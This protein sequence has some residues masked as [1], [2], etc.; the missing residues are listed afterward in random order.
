MNQ[1][2]KLMP[3]V[4]GLLTQETYNRGDIATI[5]T[6][7][8][9]EVEVEVFNLV[10][11]DA[12][13][14]RIYSVIRA[15]G[16]NSQTRAE[17]KAERRRQWAEGAEQKSN[18]FYEKSN[19]HRDFLSLG[20][21]IK[22]GHH[23][24]GRHRRI[25]EQANNNMGK[26]VELTKKADRHEQV[27]EYWERRAKDINL[28]MPESLEYFEFKLEE[29]TK[30]QQLLKDRPELREHSYSLTYASKAVKDITKKIAIAR[31]LWAE[32]EAK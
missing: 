21:P 25:I 29:A 14:N 24:E 20:E 18:D 15:D 22:V 28:S 30:K 12:E 1:F 19:Q 11:T 8:G 9:K 7:Y 27:A 4:W 5:T 31:I 10:K 23:S 13:G 17:A 3:N 2:K 32:T 16:T 26:S 6:K